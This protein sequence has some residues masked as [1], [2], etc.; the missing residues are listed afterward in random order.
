MKNLKITESA[1]KVIKEESLKY[2]T[3]TGGLLIGTLKRPIVIKTSQAGPQ[4]QVSNIS[5][6]NDTEYDNQILQQAIKE[7][8]GKLKLI[9]YWHKH[10]IGLIHPSPGDFDQAC[11]I[12]KRNEREGD[13][14]PVYFIITNVKEEVELYCY[15]LTPNQKDFSQLMIEIISDNAKEVEEAMQIEPIV[16]QPQEMD[17][18]KGNFQFYM[19]KYG[20]DRLKQEINSLVQLGYKVRVYATEQLCI[21]LEKDETILCYTPP[22]YPLN[23]PRFFKGNR[24]IQYRLPIWNSTF[25]IADILKRTKN[26]TKSKRRQYESDNTKTN[27]ERATIDQKI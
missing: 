17:Y 9:G 11:E 22:E 5:Y 7:S 1:Y 20:Y 15:S 12:V 23:P 16:I 18:W 4:A 13:N 3:E 8:K 26:F 2:K 10:I 19:T 25:K 24:E 6:A 14:R 27:I 21:K